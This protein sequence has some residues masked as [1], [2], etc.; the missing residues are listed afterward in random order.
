LG[1]KIT[2]LTF[3]CT[4]QT[5]DGNHDTLGSSGAYEMKGCPE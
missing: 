5:M 1:L 2:E 4:L 3:K